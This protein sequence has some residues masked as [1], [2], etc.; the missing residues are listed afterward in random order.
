MHDLTIS[1]AGRKIRPKLSCAPPGGGCE[2]AGYGRLVVEQSGDPTAR[3][4]LFLEPHVERQRGLDDVASMER[5]QGD[6]PLEGGA[7]I[8][9]AGE[10]SL[11]RPRR[12]HPVNAGK[13]HTLDVLI[14]RLGG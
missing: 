12:Q 3:L 6:E 2:S 1:R 9:A 13:L 11:E 7:A 5:A 8:R 4:G 14:D 10:E